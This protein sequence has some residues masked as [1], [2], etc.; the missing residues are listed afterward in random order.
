MTE[1]DTNSRTGMYR[2]PYTPHRSGFDGGMY[3][4]LFVLTVVWIILPLL[5]LLVGRVEFSLSIE[6][7]WTGVDVNLSSR[8]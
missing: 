2:V 6:I 4:I 1:N 3:I 7:Y 8:S 5:A